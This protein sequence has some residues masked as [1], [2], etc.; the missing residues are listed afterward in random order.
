[1]STVKDQASSA[2][3]N[4]EEENVETIN[5]DN[6]TQNNEEDNEDMDVIREDTEDTEHR[7]PV[8]KHMIRDAM[9]SFTISRS[10]INNEF[11]ADFQNIPRVAVKSVKKK[12]YVI[13]N[14]FYAEKR[15]DFQSIPRQD[16]TIDFRKGIE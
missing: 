9:K 2:S 12:T 7:K 15:K 1:M 14:E 5:E 16:T 8:K 11:Y 10:V 13:K 6:S 4:E 3:C